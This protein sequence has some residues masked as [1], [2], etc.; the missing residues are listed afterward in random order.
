M[1]WPRLMTSVEESVGSSD[2][3]DYSALSIVVNEEVKNNVKPWGQGSSN[4]L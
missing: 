1:I 2:V 4:F 3:L